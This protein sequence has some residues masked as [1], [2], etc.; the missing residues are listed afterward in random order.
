MSN[1]KT[2]QD[3]HSVLPVFLSRQETRAYYNKISKVYDLLA[4][5]SEAP[6]RNAGLKKLAPQ[7]G[8]KILE[9]GFGTGHVLCQLAEKVGS[10]GKVLGIDLSE[11][12]LKLSE[13]RLRQMNLAERV[14]LICGDAT[15][16]P[17]SD[18]SV[19]AVFMSFTLEL[20][21]TDEIPVVLAECRR[22]LREDGRAVVVG[23]SKTGGKKTMVK[24]YEWTHSHFP[25][26]LDCRPIFVAESFKNAGFHIA[27]TEIKSMWVPVEIVLAQKSAGGQN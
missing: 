23:M 17:Y 5:H 19:D 14:D 20:F 6:V 10:G 4:D 21:P 11:E 18:A 7:T 25:N 27:D 2:H 9:I 8:E 1:R 12:M 24:I 22:I 26:Y 15:R 3:H 16:M 13:A